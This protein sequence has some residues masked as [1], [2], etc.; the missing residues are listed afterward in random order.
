M[1]PKEILKE[2][3]MKTVS[4]TDN[5]FD[6]FFSRFKHQSY[7]KGQVIIADGDKVRIDKALPAPA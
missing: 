7:K 1:Q 3:I 2:H 5:Q 4:L 6:Y